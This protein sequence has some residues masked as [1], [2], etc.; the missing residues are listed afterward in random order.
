MKTSSQPER[1]SALLVVLWAII[2]LTGAIF[3]WAKIV[4]QDVQVHGYASATLEA[5]AMA[6]SGVIVALHPKVKKQTPLLEGGPGDGLSYRARILSEGG[7][8][9]LNWIAGNGGEPRRIAMFKQWLE[10][11][12]LGFQEREHFVDCLLDYVDPDNTHR[13]NGAE[14]EGDYHAANRP[15]NELSEVEGIKGS[16]P[17]TSSPGWKDELTLESSGP[18]DILSARENILRL[19]PGFSDARIKRFL[20]LRAGADGIEGNNDDPVFQNLAQALTSV[21]FSAQEIQALNGMVTIND[22][23]V[24]VVSV[25]QSGKVIRQVDVVARKGGSTPLILS[26]KE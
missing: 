23:I 5:R 6:H 9:N 13:L 2:V 12:G 18:I 21:G 19:I 20:V 1:G 3:T 10:S 14:D 4:Q 7:K 15:L 26:W 24:H 8:L 22:P 11:H 17:L 16:E 25:G